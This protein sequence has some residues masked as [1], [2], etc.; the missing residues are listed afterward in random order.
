[1]AVNFAKLPALPRLF[2][3]APT[4][5]ASE[6]TVFPN[7]VFRAKPRCD[8]QVSLEGARASKPFYRATP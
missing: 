8:G 6:Q 5:S 3:V 1:M 4:A 7:Q 2:S